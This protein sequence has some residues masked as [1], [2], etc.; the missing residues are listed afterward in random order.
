MTIDS[1]HRAANMPADQPVALAEGHSTRVILMGDGPLYHEALAELSKE[2]FPVQRFGAG[3]SI[4]ESRGAKGLADILRQVA[5]PSRPADQPQSDNSLIC[6]KLRLHPDTARAFWNDVDVD[7]TLGEYKILHLLVSDAGNYKTYRVIY[8]RL[9][10]EGF[11]A[12]DGAQGYKANVRSAI[13]RMRN[14]FRVLDSDF[15]RIEN[16]TGFGYCWKTTP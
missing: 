15:D 12:G 3:A 16:Y 6:G 4:C 13:K 9:R 1:E 5:K 10:H 2:G 11:I 7:L 8:D 14:K